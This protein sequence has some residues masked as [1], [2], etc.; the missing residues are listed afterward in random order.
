LHSRTILSFP[1]FTLPFK[2]G[3]DASD[4]GLG[5][6]LSQDGPTGPLYIA[7]AAR[8]LTDAER[9][10]GYGATKR[11]LVAVIFA[12]A[13]FR[14]YIWGVHFTLYTDH[15]ALTFMFTQRHVNPMLNNWLDQLL[16]YNFDVVHM[17]GIHQHRL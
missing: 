14:Y 1:D 7:F 4:R 8:S 2:V 9:G 3:T 12:L 5:A 17:P 15:K 13:R 16:D 11:E 6:V 10:K